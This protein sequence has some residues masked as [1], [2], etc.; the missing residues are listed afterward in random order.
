M[1]TL[2]AVPPS[3]DG[4]GAVLANTPVRPPVAEVEFLSIVIVAQTRLANNRDGAP[5]GLF[6]GRVRLLDYGAAKSGI[7]FCGV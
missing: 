6:F 7:G 3:A 2:R 5:A 4:Q 1:I